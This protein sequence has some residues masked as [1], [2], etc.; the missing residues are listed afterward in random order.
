MTSHRILIVEDEASLSHYYTEVLEKAGY[1]SRAA[2]SC[3]SA[4][5]LYREYQ[6]HLV[7]LD[8]YLGHQMD[9]FDVLVAIRQQTV[10]AAVMVLTAYGN[11]ARLVRAIELGADNFVSKPVSR[12]HLL[13]RV[14][15]QLRLRRDPI[16]AASGG[17]FRYGTFVIDL[18]ASQLHDLT[19]NRRRPLSD[20]ERRVL[21]SLL[22]TA[23]EI[24]SYEA[25]LRQIWNV[26][27]PTD[28][29]YLT[30]KPVRDAVFRIRAKLEL[31]GAQDILTSVYE[32]GVIIRRPDEV[33]AEVGVH[34]K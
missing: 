27:P 33:L 20:T 34:R 11:D 1:E 5:K 14:R 24:V 19:A 17:R 7:I 8:L 32:K 10:Q 30:N 18:N 29:N 23:G 2:S 6:P 9:G 28:A 16:R 4:V 13:A 12:E 21:S 3:Q 31:V 26:D 22:A 15:A 25:L